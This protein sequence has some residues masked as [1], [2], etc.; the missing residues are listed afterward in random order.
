MMPARR[1][2]DEQDRLAALRSLAVLDT[3]PEQGFDDIVLVAKA[4]TGAKI[5]LVSLVD[6]ERQWFKAKAGMEICE[7]SRDVAFCAYTILQPEVFWVEDAL[8][9]PRFQ[10]SPLVTGEHR[11]RLYIGAPLQVDGHHM[12]ALCVM[13]D[14]PRPYDAGIAEALTALARSVSSLLASRRAEQFASRLLEATTDAIIC[15][16]EEGQVAFWNPAAQNLFGYSPKDV[17]D[18]PAVEFIPEAQ[19]ARYEADLGDL[20]AGRRLDSLIERTGRHKDG[21]EFPLEVS[22]AAWS[23][24]ERRMTGWILRDRSAQKAFERALAEARTKAEAANVAKSAFLANMSHEIRTPLNGVIGLTDLLARTDLDA[25]QA[26]MAALIKSSGEQLERLL[27]DILDL[28]RIEAGE[29]PLTCETFLLA[30][31]VRSAFELCALK[32]DEKGLKMRLDMDPAAERH[33]RGDPVRLRQILI[34]LMSNAVK[35]THQGSVALRVRRLEGERFEFEV[36]DTGIGFDPALK[37]DLFSRF[38]Q[39]DTS[40]TRRFGGSGLG[41]A[42]CRELADLM[43][44]QIDC[45]SRPGRGSTFTVTV[46]LEAAATAVAEAD[47]LMAPDR[48]FS[49]LVADDN[50]TNRRVIELILQSVGAEVLCVEDGAAAVDAFASRSFDVVFMDM[51][52]PVMNGL[53]ATRLIRRRETA[54]GLARTPVLMLT[55]NTMPEHVQSALDAGA[56]AHLTKP[57]VAARLL[58]AVSAVLTSPTQIETAHATA[59]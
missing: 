16:N 29:M 31:S 3:A 44:G 2:K 47:P 52:M 13:D 58:E 45:D 23:E 7:T 21:R 37:A 39:A 26:E 54:D 17:L 22:A 25:R 19:R 42:I 15:T 4:L 38:N 27:G 9:D 34:N 28:A 43:G 36:T 46:P 10:D 32:A 30:D 53:E 6:A 18:K 57:I 24:G 56:D 1:P 55:A 14:A 35:F 5:A 50:A 51:M 12:G 8:D 41:L 11:I 40:Y 33:V 20:L 48:P 59:A 49:I